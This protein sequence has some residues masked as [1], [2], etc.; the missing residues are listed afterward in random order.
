MF[1]RR[2]RLAAL[3]GAAAL[4]A[5]IALPASPAEAQSDCSFT[6][7]GTPC[8][9]QNVGGLWAAGDT[10]GDTVNADAENG[11]RYIYV[12]YETVGGRTYGYISTTNGALC[13]NF[14]TGPDE[15]YLDSCPAGDP[16]EMFNLV[17][18]PNGSWCISSLDWGPGPIL[19]AE[20]NGDALGFVGPGTAGIPSAPYKYDEWDAL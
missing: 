16:N 12:P 8:Y 9:L 15:I 18:C 4:A 7:V 3:A 17:P 13:W 6:V 20:Y 19:W 11:S 5:A 1:S 2:A 10:H 14:I